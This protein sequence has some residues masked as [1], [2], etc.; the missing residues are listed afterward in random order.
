MVR[1][2]GSRARDLHH[3]VVLASR[4]MRPEATAGLTLV[5]MRAPFPRALPLYGEDADRSD[6]PDLR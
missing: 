5:V 3:E 6:H 2:Y 1:S 4:L